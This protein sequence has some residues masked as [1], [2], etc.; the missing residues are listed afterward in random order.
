MEESNN[1]TKKSQ[2]LQ[3]IIL[4]FIFWVIVE[5]ITVWHARLA[6]WISYM[7]FILFL[8]LG[9]ILIFYFFIKKDWSEK[10]L[11]I[12]ML[13][14]MYVFEIFIWSNPL[15]FNIFLFIPVSLLLIS[16]WGC[17]TFIPLWIVNRTLKEHKWQVICY[18]LWILV[19]LL[20][21]ILV[22]SS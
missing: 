11:F 13:I 17:L 21:L 3:Y 6:E 9:I 12:V 16:I 7:P 19:A 4:S 10:R 22:L 20:M 15:L 2:G 1:F 18:L 14:V 5:Y 8:Y